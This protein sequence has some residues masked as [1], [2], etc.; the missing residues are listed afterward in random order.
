VPTI[1]VRAYDP[2]TRKTVTVEYPPGQIQHERDRVKEQTKVRGTQTRAKTTERHKAKESTK[3]G[4]TTTTLRKRDEYEIVT[5][6]GISDRAVLERIAQNRYHLIGKSERRCVARTRDL[7]D[8]RESD[9]LNLSAGDA[10]LIDWDEFNREL[11]SSPDVPD[12]TKVEHLVARGFNRA[13]ARVVAR[14]YAQLEGLDRPLR[15]KEVTY[16]YD[17]E[18]GIDI[19]LELYDFIVVDGV[20]PDSGAARTSRAD[21]HRAAMVNH[22]G[23]RIGWSREQREAM[24]RRHRP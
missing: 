10:V 16:E 18:Q 14:R 1:V 5:V 8:M 17:A 21:A 12:E 24:K 13:I 22:D 4:K 23:E 3:K 20:R 2:V 6:H 9:M 15:V 11:L 7:R 19:E